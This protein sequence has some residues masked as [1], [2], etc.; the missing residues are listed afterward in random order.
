MVGV[1]AFI[2]LGG[3]SVEVRELQEQ[4]A[5]RDGGAVAAGRFGRQALE[6]VGHYLAEKRLRGVVAN[7]AA[8]AVLLRHEIDLLYERDVG[9]L[10]AEIREFDQPVFG[11][12]LFNAEAVA[13]VLGIDANVG[14]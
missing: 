5:A 7:R 3:K 8:R 1:L 6:R 11:K 10:L 12:L 4:P 13:P 14:N 9:S 2:R